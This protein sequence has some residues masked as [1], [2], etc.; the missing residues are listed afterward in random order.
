MV[1]LKGG[2]G[3]LH[4]G[5]K[6][7]AVKEGDIQWGG[8]AVGER[9]WAGRDSQLQAANCWPPNWAP[10]PWPLPCHLLTGEPEGMVGVEVA[11]YHLASTDLKETVKIRG[12]VP[13]AGRRRGNVN[14]DKDSV[15][16]NR[17][18]QD[19]SRVIIR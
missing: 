19:L 13:W 18:R 1:E 10:P 5:G 4:H 2:E 8:L 11:E 6:E 14:I 12:V 7:M 9:R 17:N 3:G 15:E 16:V